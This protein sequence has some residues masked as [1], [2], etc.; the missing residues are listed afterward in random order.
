M[1]LTFRSVAKKLGKAGKKALKKG[2]A[3]NPLLKALPGGALVTTAVGMAFSGGGGKRSTPGTF[4]GSRPGL[5]FGDVGDFIKRV[6]PGGAT[7]RGRVAPDA[8]TGRCPQGYHPA[9][10]GRGCVRNRRTNVANP[11][12]LSRALRRAEGFEKL[13]RRTVTALHRGPSKFKKRAK[14]R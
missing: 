3:G 10:D 7:G 12:A 6:A 9:K 13:A 1:P 8:Q 11:R 14:K 4:T 5:D 2:I